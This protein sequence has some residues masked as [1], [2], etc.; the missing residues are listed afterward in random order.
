MKQR[1]DEWLLIEI[2]DVIRENHGKRVADVVE[3]VLREM[4]AKYD[5]RATL[6]NILYPD[7]MNALAL[8]TY[9]DAKQ[10]SERMCKLKCAHILEDVAAIE[11]KLRTDS[12][13][14]EDRNKVLD[15]LRYYITTPDDQVK[16]KARE[17]LREMLK[18]IFE[19]IEE[20]YSTET[21]TNMLSSTE[22]DALISISYLDIADGH[23]GPVIT[24]VYWRLMQ[25]E[26]H[27][28]INFLRF[29]PSQFS[30]TEPEYQKVVF[31][32]QKTD[33]VPDELSS[34]A[35]GLLHAVRAYSA[36]TGGYV[37]DIRRRS[38]TTRSESY[39]TTGDRTSLCSTCSYS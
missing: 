1:V 21:T 23:W 30:L 18:A 36:S 19:H 12:E 2:D 24:S 33:R 29:C 32:A 31:F 35:S 22:R 37:I 38:G 5:D 3:N 9:E 26:V 39:R 4:D 20:K 28:M 8:A 10:I 6:F 14:W 13:S 27:G 25:E 16:E 34:L 11:L 15:H 7:E 17:L